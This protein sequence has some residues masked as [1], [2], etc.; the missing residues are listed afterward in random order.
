MTVADAASLPVARARPVRWRVR[1]PAPITALE[2]FSAA[3]GLPPKL[4]AMLYARGVHSV[5]ALEPALQRSP[6]P[7]LEEAAKRIV[8]AIRAKKRI[9]IH[10]DYDADGI[11]GS[12]VLTLGLRELGAN[13][14]AFIPHRL[15]DGYGVHPDRVPEHLESCDLFI[16]V[17]CGVSNLEEIARIVAGGVEAIVT[18]H[19]SPGHDLPGCLIVH[20]ALAPNYHHDL[21]ALT[22]SGVAFHLLWAVRQELGL[23][24]P[25]EFADLAAIGTIA[26]C[27]PL[28]GENRALVKIGLERM[29]DSRWPGIRAVVEA[30]LLRGQGKSTVTAKDVAF[31]LA[32]RINAAGRLGEA[33]VA[34]E[35]LTTESPSRALTLATYLDA[36]NQERKAIQD[37]MF[38][39]ALE[40][41]DPDAPAL[42]VNK[43]GWHAGVMGIV[44]SKIL[45]R[46][47][48]PVFIIAEGKGSVRS[49]PGISAVNGLRHVADTLKRYGGHS[50]AAG[51]AILDDK[52]PAFTKGILEFC[53]T[54]PE[55]VETIT[56]DAML[57]PDEVNF[58]LMRSLEALEPFGEGHPAPVFLARGPLSEA[59]PLG[60]TR[61]HFQYRLGGIKGKQWHTTPEFERGDVVDAAV[62]V[63]ENDWQGKVS[64]E[65]GTKAIR[66]AAPLRLLESDQDDGPVYERVETRA[67][68][69]RLKV[70]PAHVYA[71][72]ASLEYVRKACPNVPVHESIEAPEGPITLIAMPDAERLEAWIQAGIPIR[73]ALTERTLADLE[74]RGF[75][76]LAR[77]RDAERRRRA[78]ESIPPEARKLIEGIRESGASLDGNDAY[79]DNPQLVREEAHAYRFGAFCQHYRHSDDASFSRVVRILFGPQ[80]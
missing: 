63:E 79:R 46:Y 40:V 14:H 26:D 12:S 2:E 25:Y 36:R 44:A 10:G 68:L 11:T 8:A 64:L 29:K 35:L 69:E 77:L 56:L 4:A 45:E 6:N 61:A 78:G 65:F 21:P 31:V 38:K 27:A 5:D 60:K 43:S 80:A 23:E 39:E 30:Q 17:D 20:P 32:P 16:T 33:D 19:H 55:P 59:G 75:W 42:I 66:Y 73:F 71:N 62:A 70:T 57:H 7:A 13:V 50:Q 22:G 49:T 18:D 1:A 54:H 28:L 52:I 74:G 51:F 15:T 48:K 47:Y 24:P 72:S 37:R 3:L 41:V 58:D 34:L 76:T 9:R 53:A 67:E